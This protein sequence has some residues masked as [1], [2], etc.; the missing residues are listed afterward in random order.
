MRTELG[1]VPGNGNLGT[2]SRRGGGRIVAALVV[3]HDP[4]PVIADRQR[5]HDT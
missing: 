1:R 5:R 2:T 4:G 3:G